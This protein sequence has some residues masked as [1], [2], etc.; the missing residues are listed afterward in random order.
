MYL[1][2]YILC[3]YYGTIY[4]FGFLIYSNVNTNVLLYNSGHVKVKHVDQSDFLLQTR[5]LQLEDSYWCEAA[6]SHLSLSCG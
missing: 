3:N 2:L 1:T 6:I 5:R 4:R